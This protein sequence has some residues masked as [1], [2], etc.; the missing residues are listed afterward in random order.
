M[1][2]IGNDLPSGSSLKVD[3]SLDKIEGE[4]CIFGTVKEGSVEDISALM[5]PDSLLKKG[6]NS[7]R[8]AGEFCIEW[9]DMADSMLVQE[10]G[11]AG[12]SINECSVGDIVLCGEALLFSEAFWVEMCSN[13][14]FEEE[15]GLNEVG[16]VVV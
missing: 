3:E 15:C 7:A 2:L 1:S 13:L 6:V 14:V 16:G 9:L 4:D 5:G 10:Y 12:E 8:T 11:C